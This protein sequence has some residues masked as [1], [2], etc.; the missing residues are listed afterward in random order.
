MKQVWEK[1]ENSTLSACKLGVLFNPLDEY[2]ILPVL[3]YD[4]I[5]NLFDI[6]QAVFA[7]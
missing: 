6:H 7:I 5:S 3:A 2:V 4:Q 1:R